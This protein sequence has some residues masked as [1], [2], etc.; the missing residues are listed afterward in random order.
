[1]N[2]LTEIAYTDPE[3]WIICRWADGSWCHYN[4]RSWFDWMS[5]DYAV[6]SVLSYDEDYVPVKTVPYDGPIEL[7]QQPI[8]RQIK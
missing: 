2:D 6:L 7:P 1:M 5:D 4:W 8:K 3:P